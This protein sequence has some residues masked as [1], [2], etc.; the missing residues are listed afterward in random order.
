MQ[1]L[2][3]FLSPMCIGM[4]GCAVKNK[5]LIAAAGG[6]RP[7]VELANSKNLG[8]CVEAI[9]A[10]ANLAVNGTPPPSSL[11]VGGCEGS[12]G[13]RTISYRILGRGTCSGSYMHANCLLQPSAP[14]S[15]F[16]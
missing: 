15:S 3:A 5:E 9:A 16:S 6:I 10:L 12:E 4:P 1:P 11:M 8:V 7:L 13:Y 14:P 2:K